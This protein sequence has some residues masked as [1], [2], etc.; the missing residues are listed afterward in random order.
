MKI[1]RQNIVAIVPLFLCLALAISTLIYFFVKRELVR[2][3]QEEAIAASTSIAAFV[4]PMLNG[5]ANDESIVEA[6]ERAQN[7]GKILR[8]TINRPEDPKVAYLDF[9]PNSLADFETPLHEPLGS[10][11]ASTPFEAGNGQMI[12]EAVSV[13]NGISD[14]ALGQVT[15]LIDANRLSVGLANIWN[16]CAIGTLVSIALGGAASAL[17][18]LLLKR[19]MH[20]LQ[21]SVASVADGVDIADSQ[22]DLSTKGIREITDLRNTVATMGSVLHWTIQKSQLLS[23]RGAIAENPVRSMGAQS[24]T[25]LDIDMHLLPVGQNSKSNTFVSAFRTSQGELYGVFGRVNDNNGVEPDELRTSAVI[26]Y[27][28]QRLDSRG[29][30][31]EGVLQRGC[32][33]FDVLDVTVIRCEVARANSIDVFQS[34]AQNEIERHCYLCDGGMKLFHNGGGELD[35]LF[36]G[37]TTNLPL[38][39]SE[40]LTRRAVALVDQSSYPSG[41]IVAAISISSTSESSLSGPVMFRAGADSPSVIPSHA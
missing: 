27:L 37:L 22:V 35:L 31:V 19:E 16:L 38:M 30:D 12:V 2:G 21:Q 15:V 4:S 3:L 13:M 7:Y 34:G 20:P 6:V 23:D 9:N 18:S 40:D 33:L 25:G 39:P 17:V 11:V 1:W 36:S 24:L 10:G 29:S 14:E 28:Q 26:Y 5:E 8:V 32:S 41:L